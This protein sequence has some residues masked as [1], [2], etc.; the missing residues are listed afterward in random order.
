MMP[1][2]ILIETAKRKGL[3]NKEYIEKDYFQDLLLFNIYKKTN[4]L[5][6]KGGTALYKLYGLQRFSEDLDFSLLKKINADEIINIIKEAV[7]QIEGAKIK[8]IKKTHGSLLIKVGFDGLLTKYNTV[9]IDISTDNPVIEK[10]DVKSYVSQYIDINPFSIRILNLKEILAE[11]IHS[12]FARQKARDLYDLFFLLKF[13]EFNKQFIDKKLSNFDMK[14]NFKE[15]R[16]RADDLENIWEKELK[17]FILGEL[18]E[19]K[20]ARDFVIKEVK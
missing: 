20:L 19:F 8:E 2:E 3:V 7:N 14:F 17:S 15:F 5:I 10:F 12:I 4:I 1:K 11:K 13:V 18:P 16:K 6:F 9:R